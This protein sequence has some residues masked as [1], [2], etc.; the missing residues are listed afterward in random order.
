MSWQPQ[1]YTREIEGIW[2]G[3]DLGV[4]YS[5]V[6]A[7]YE[8]KSVICATVNENLCY[9]ILLNPIQ[10]FHTHLE[11][12]GQ[13]WTTSALKIFWR[14]ANSE[15]VAMLNKT[16]L[17][18]FSSH[19]CNLLA[20]WMKIQLSATMLLTRVPWIWLACCACVQCTQHE[21]LPAVKDSQRLP[22]MPPSHTSKAEIASQCIWE[23]RS[24]SNTDTEPA[25]CMRTV[26]WLAESA[27]HWES[28]QG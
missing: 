23:F 17:G 21:Q 9:S 8:S 3:G 19:G 25:L 15:A 27:A 12:Q 13:L 7:G 2:R 6:R 10:A 5:A 28:L 24:S 26:L 16:M 14:S 22:T 18:C 1:P 11:F 4:L 20:W